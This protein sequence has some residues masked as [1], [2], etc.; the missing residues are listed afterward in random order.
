MVEVG[1]TNFVEVCRRPVIEWA[2]SHR[3]ELLNYQAYEWNEM[4]HVE[5]V[6][7]RN[8]L[9]QAISS[10]RQKHNGGIDLATVDMIYNWGMIPPSFP[11]RDES[12]IL[13]TT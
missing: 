13:R 9:E 5:S 7:A 8:Q 1:K 3:E 2:G 12:E 10:S 11:L 6:E 4:T